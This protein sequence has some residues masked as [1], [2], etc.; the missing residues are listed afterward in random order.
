MAG[1]AQR[2]RGQKV[3]TGIAVFLTVI[4][5]TSVICLGLVR[6][7]IP[8]G[9][10]AGFWY[11][12][13]GVRIAPCL[14]SDLG[15]HPAVHIGDQECVYEVRGIDFWA[16]YSVPTSEVR[17][18]FDKARTALERRVAEGGSDWW[19]T[20]GYVLWLNDPNTDRTSLEAL[21]TKMEEG[22]CEMRRQRGSSGSDG[23]A[24]SQHGLEW[25]MA[26]AKWDWASFVFE[27]LYLGGLVWF[28]LWPGIKGKG[29]RSW[30]WRLGLLPV[31]L[32]LPCWMGYGT[33]AVDMRH[34]MPGMRILYPWLLISLPPGHMNAAD[35][36]IVQHIP[37]ILAPLSYGGQWHVSVL[38]MLAE[39]GG[40]HTMWGPTYMIGAGA[41]L[42]VCVLAVA[43]VGR[44]LQ[45][46]SL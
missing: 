28:A 10:A 25:Q 32:M 12:A 13:A 40:E 1:N 39:Y 7:P 45:T 27:S 24:L 14:G 17:D 20:L 4:I 29:V 43:T 6:R 16:T 11:A 46:Q 30:A 21:V 35:I 26:Q 37:P 34:P 3:W 22:F 31:L 42:A 18:T 2:R 8:R 5:L 19:P 15:G 41:A 23:I 38:S 33:L 44:R 36:L 9:T